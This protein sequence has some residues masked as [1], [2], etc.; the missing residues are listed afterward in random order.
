MN[1]AIRMQLSAFADGEL[2]DNEKELLLRRLSQD[3]DMRRQVAE[4]LALGRAMRG[5]VPV[6]GIE[7]L[8]DRIATAIGTLEAHTDEVSPPVADA[9]V[10]SNRRLVRPVAGLA[11]AAVVALL[12]IFGLQIFSELPELPPSAPAIAQD[13]S[14]STQPP[15]DKLLDRFRLMHETEAA[16]SSMR[17]RFTS[18][19]LRQ[20]LAVESGTAEEPETD[21]ASDETRD[22]GERS[23]NAGNAGNAEVPDAITE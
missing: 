6:R 8:R 20:G 2:P 18:I 11:T 13:A 22:E 4:Y 23:G 3:P 9:D 1:E 15:P 16:D 14:F 10:P 12:A 19:E 17:T 7:A 5:E 21:Q